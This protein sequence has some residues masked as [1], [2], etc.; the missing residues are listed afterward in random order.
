M[1]EAGFELR[2]KG[3]RPEQ[4]SPSWPAGLRLVPCRR[5]CAGAGPRGTGPGG[6][7][8]LEPAPLWEDTPLLLPPHSLCLLPKAT[9]RVVGAWLPLR[10]APPGRAAIAGPG[11]AGLPWAPKLHRPPGRVSAHRPQVGKRGPIK[12]PTGTG[13]SPPGIIYNYQGKLSVSLAPSPARSAMGGV[14]M[15]VCRNLSPVF[16]QLDAV[17]S[18]NSTLMA[19][20]IIVLFSMINPSSRVF[21]SRAY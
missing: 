18:D 13:W 12:L 11:A 6:A 16:E 15:S 10:H 19:V 1:A 7:S 17:A 3:R 2:W 20:V 14:W 21:Y 5:D 4:H 9:V 8:T